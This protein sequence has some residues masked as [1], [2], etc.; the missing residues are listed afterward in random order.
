MRLLKK[1]KKEKEKKKQ[2]EFLIGASFHQWTLISEFFRFR[3]IFAR[4]FKCKR[5]IER[6]FR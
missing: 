6:F 5:S 1:K 4:S 2:A 3:A